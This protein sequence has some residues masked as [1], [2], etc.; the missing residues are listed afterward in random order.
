[1]NILLLRFCWIVAFGLSLSTLPLFGQESLFFRHIDDRKGLSQNS[2]YAIAQDGDGF[3]WFGTRNGLNRYD[4]YNMVVYEVGRDSSHSGLIDNEI[5]LLYYDKQ[6]DRLWISS[7]K[8]LCWYEPENESFRNILFQRGKNDSLTQEY[9]RNILRDSKGNLWAGTERGLFKFQEE[10]GFFVEQ[11]ISLE[12]GYVEHN[13]LIWDLMEDK[14]TSIWIGSR[15]GPIVMKFDSKNQPVFERNIV[16]DLDGSPL[17]IPIQICVQDGQDNY[18]FAAPKDGVYQWKAGKGLIHH[19][20]DAFDGGSLNDDDVRSMEIDNKGNVWIGTFRGLSIFNGKSGNFSR[21]EKELGIERSLSN[22]SVRAI[23][24]DS[25]GSTWVGTYY[26]GV[27]YYNS[28]SYRFTH[29]QPK[30]GEDKLGHAVVSAFWEDDNNHLWIGT[31]GGGINCL[32]PKNGK[33]KHYLYESGKLNSLS[34]NNVKAM[35]GRGD[36]LWVGTFAEGLNLLNIRSGKWE[37]F[38]KEKPLGENLS[39]DNVYGLLL[40]GNK[41]WIATYGGGLNIMDLESRQVDK[42]GPDEISNSGFKARGVRVLLKD[43]KGAIWVGTTRGLYKIPNPEDSVLDFQHVI[44][45]GMVCSLLEGNNGKIWVGF[46]KK[47]LFRLA[48]DGTT[49]EVYSKANGLPGNSVFGLLEDDQSQI[50]LS[51]EKGLAKINRADNSVTDYNYSDGLANLEYNFNA[52]Y[53]SSLGEMFFGGTKGFTS[54]FP[55][56][57]HTNTFVP[58]VVFT[59]LSSANRLVKPHDETA[60]I[61]ES[62]NKVKHI[63]F[64]YNKANFTLK[65]AALDFLNPDNNQYMYKLEGLDKEWKHIKGQPEVS[66]TLQRS[67]DYVFK[68]KGGNN[69]GI[70]NKTEKTLKITVLPPPWQS[71]IAYFIYLSLLIILLT[72]LYRLILMQ[73]RLQLEKI[74]KGQQEELHQSKLRFYTNVTHE[75]RTP[76]TL[77]LGPVEE[78]IRNGMDSIGRERQLQSIHQNAKR[79]LRLVNQLLDFRSLEKDYDRL[80]VAEGNIVRFLREVYLSFQEKARTSDIAYHFESS[81]ESIPLFFDRDKLEKVF[82]NIISNAFKF[83]PSGGKIQIAV[84]TQKDWVEVR[85]CDSGPGIKGELVEKVFDRFFQGDIDPSGS[86]ASSGIGLALAKQL[87]ELH[88]GKIALDKGRLKGA[89]FKIT[90]PKGNEHFVP[91]D[92][93]ADFKS[94]ENMDAYL[95]KFTTEVAKEEKALFEVQESDS[96]QETILIVED[97]LEVQA[98]I[99]KIF[100]PF[101][102]VILANNGKQGLEKAIEFSPDIIISDIMMP[103]MDGINLCSQLKSK[104]ETSHIPVILLTAR[105]GQI[106]KV[107]GLETGADAYLTKPFSPYELKLQ[108]FNLLESRKRIKQRFHTVLKLEPKEITLTSPDEKFISKAISVVEEYMD[109]PDFNVDLFARELAVSR[110]LLFT[111]LKGITNQTPNNFVKSLRLKRSAQLLSQSNFRVAE[112]AYQVGFRD[113]RYFS[114]CFQKQFNMTPTAY[115]EEKMMEV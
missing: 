101:F 90:I 79:L 47:G 113:S 23:F 17:N 91:Q 104:L 12:D 3:M 114:K 35:V 68:L 87:I 6:I 46:Y 109:D 66:Y 5:I 18:W 16:K 21:Y 27:S 44:K 2:V 57:I 1:M 8:G 39:D 112:V 25:R 34:G 111:K 99:H 22:G 94:S 38:D 105:T 28:E 43:A 103:E 108:V 20:H 115:R 41:L 70:W 37:K 67:G 73:Q 40:N 32:N 88:G 98:Y 61:S 59:S 13:M 72:V 53:K 26:G 60:I 74:A 54:F 85:I 58:P 102:H 77:I 30:E 86:E 83:T 33:Y 75:F 31:E 11:P 89:C 9:V 51:T 110:P 49:E 36:S 15:L 14:D 80:E 78:L 29:H 84:L 81:E 19:K 56:S 64:P 106:F 50:W 7:P 52:A 24:F 107:E 95:E 71:P 100:T 69:D 92:F 62:I 97:N 63:V 4:G 76:L 45:D 55:R 65:F 48:A 10:T 93:L 82:F 42:Y 96:P